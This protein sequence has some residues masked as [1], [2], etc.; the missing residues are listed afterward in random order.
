MCGAILIHVGKI[1]L[2]KPESPSVRNILMIA[3]NSPLYNV[4]FPLTSV[5]MFNHKIISPTSLSAKVTFEIFLLNY[6]HVD[7]RALLLRHQMVA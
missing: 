2:Y 5:S 7:C 3:S 6:T 4:P 1:P